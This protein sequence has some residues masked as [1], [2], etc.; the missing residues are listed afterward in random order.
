[1]Q[2]RSGSRWMQRWQPSSPHSF[3]WRQ[4]WQQ[5][6]AQQHPA[7]PCA[8]Q[9]SLHVSCTTI[10]E[11]SHL[12]PL[13]TCMCCS[14]MQQGWSSTPPGSEG[15][16]CIWG[17]AD[18]LCCRIQS[19]G[20]G[21]HSGA[22]CNTPSSAPHALGPRWTLPGLDGLRHTALLPLLCPLAQGHEGQ[23]THCCVFHEVGLCTLCAIAE[24]CRGGLR[25]E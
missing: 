7:Q 9:G 25:L 18:Q 11:H 24:C 23:G 4:K 5:M 21:C 15:M 16:A 1:M 8:S 10:A 20:S 12:Q 19:R 13:T 14:G 17:E 6:P 3:F 22:C 2:G